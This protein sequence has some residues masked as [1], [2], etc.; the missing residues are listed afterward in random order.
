M[1]SSEFKNTGKVPSA[2]IVSCQ[3]LLSESTKPSIIP[4][5]VVSLYVALLE[6]ASSVSEIPSL[7]ESLSKK[8]NNVTFMSELAS[9]F[10]GSFAATPLSAAVSKP[11]AKPFVPV[12][13]AAA[14]AI[15]SL[16]V[17]A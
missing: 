17:S 12:L 9:V 3:P 7:S 6:N 8:F 1:S 14:S 11:S 5:F 13:T 15:P 10:I 16:F 4:S 2:S